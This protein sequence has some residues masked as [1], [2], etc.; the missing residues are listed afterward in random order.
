MLQFFVNLLALILF[1]SP[2][3]IYAHGGESAPGIE[4]NGTNIIP[5]SIEEAEVLSSGLDIPKDEAS[6]MY[7]VNREIKFEAD[8]TELKEED[9]D[10]A[11]TLKLNWDFGDG[12]K[13]S[14]ENITHTYKKTGSYI[15]KLKITKDDKTPAAEESVLVNIVPTKEYKLPEA[16]IV[17]DG[18]RGTKENYNILDIDLNNSLT[19]DGAQSKS[20]SSEITK[21]V[22]DFGDDKSA[23]G[24]TVKHK[25]VLPQAFATVILRTYDK[26]G[27][28]TDSSVNVR[29]SGKNEPNNPG[30]S[31]FAK[32]A[33][34]L[35]MLGVGLGGFFI[36][37]RGRK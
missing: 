24:K 9:P 27:F 31:S 18:Q 26:N 35:V 19:F 8:L 21:Y 16:V 1:L 34:F 30:I 33:P 3:V 2:G 15:L 37:K 22:W 14:G 10:I 5:Y 4:I 25:Y 20:A 6:E 23:V 32:F 11:Q 17:I 28:F 7:L 12:E 29:N 13:G 36:F